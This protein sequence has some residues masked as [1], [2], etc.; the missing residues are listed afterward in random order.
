[1][2]NN[3]PRV[4][5]GLPVFNGEKYL[6]E[7]LDSILAQTFTDFELIISDNCSTD[8]T[9]EICQAYAAQDPRI[10]YY[11]QK[12]NLGAAPNYNRVFELASGE[13]FKWAAHDDL[14]TPEYL[15]K[16]VVVLDENP[17][18]A[19]CFSRA[20]VI[21]ENSRILGGDAYNGD[22]RSSEPHIRFRNLAINL[23]NQLKVPIVIFGLM[24]T[25][26]VKKTGLMG[27]YALSD[28]VLAAE[29]A[30]NGKFFEIQE[31]LFLWRNHPEQSVRGE[32][33][34]DRNRSIWFDTSI[35]GKIFLHKWMYF[36]GY[37]KAIRRSNISA[38][39]K[40]YC[41]ILMIRWLFI[42]AH[43]KPMIKDVL[44][45]VREIIMRTFFKS[46]R[47]TIG[48]NY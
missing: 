38:Y 34:S 28:V 4:S 37:L 40:I 42:P 16:C 32:L 29:I 22:I 43:F 7:S 19:L 45:A 47:P 13:Y 36:F 41:Y 26:V 2:N 1:M 33:A 12:K 39:S 20:K 44:L 9:E 30:L 11:R 18:V 23:F 15:S 3:K 14:I 25:E 48:K 46:T 6:R 27:G 8:S 5:I 31:P 21:D 17:D 35:Q 10:S 24:R